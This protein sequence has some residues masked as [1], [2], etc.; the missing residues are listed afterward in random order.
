MIVIMPNKSLELHIVRPKPNLLPAAPK[1]A[2]TYKRRQ[3][4][5]E[6]VTAVN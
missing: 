4:S 1:T 3:W 6:P 5:E 2:S